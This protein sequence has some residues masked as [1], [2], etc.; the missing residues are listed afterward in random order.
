MEIAMGYA[1][2]C[3]GKGNKWYNFTQEVLLKG[4]YVQTEL[5]KKGYGLNKFYGLQV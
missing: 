5:L 4:G 2:T 1:F 3:L